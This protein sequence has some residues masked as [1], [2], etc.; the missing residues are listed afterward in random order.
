MPISI[1]G[2]RV[3]LVENELL[4]LMD[5]QMQ[6]ERHGA[7]VVAA[8]TAKD[9]LRC[10]VEAFDVAILDVGLPD[11]AASAVAQKL[12]VLGVPIVFHSGHTQA[13]ELSTQFPNSVCVSKPVSESHLIAALS[14]LIEASRAQTQ[15]LPHD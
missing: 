10:G 5:L 12:R 3:L 13:E 9:A 6:L 7:D 11:G 14:R 8:S 4:I 1:S 15:R 2:R